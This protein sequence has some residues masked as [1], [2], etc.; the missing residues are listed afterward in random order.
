MIFTL[1]WFVYFLFQDKLRTNRELQDLQKEFQRLEAKE[2]MEI[3]SKRKLQGYV[4]VFGVI[5]L[6]LYV[7]WWTL[8]TIHF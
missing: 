5:F 1:V 7:V 6:L 2:K 8:A 3:S 4:H